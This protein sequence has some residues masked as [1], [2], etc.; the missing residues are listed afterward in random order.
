MLTLLL[1][2]SP[3]CAAEPEKPVP[4]ALDF[5]VQ[6]LSGKPVNLADYHGKVLLVVNVASE[7]GATPQYAQ[8]QSLYK[9]HQDDGLVVLG[10]P[11]NQFGGQEPGSA[12]EIQQFCKREYSVTFPMM[13]KVDVNGDNATPFYRHLTS[14]N[15]KP[16]GQGRV[17][18]NFEKFLISRDGKVVARFPTAVSPRDSQVAK[19]V[20]RELAKSAE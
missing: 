9:E 6:S 7:C 17:G 8:L 20:K 3:L 19:A 2:C 15:A 18:W 10:F 12:E 16:K 11:C 1:V 4:A 14:Q 5:E 13:A